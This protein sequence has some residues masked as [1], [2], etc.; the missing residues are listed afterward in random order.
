MFRFWGGLLLLICFA[1]SA[2]SQVIDLGMLQPAIVNGDVV[3]DSLW[4]LRAITPRI[5]T[6][7]TFEGKTFA[8]LCT[9][10]LIAPDVV[11]TAAHCLDT[12]PGGVLKVEVNFGHIEMP[13]PDFVIHP[14][15]QELDTTLQRGRP[16]V[17]GGFND[18]G[19]IFLAKPVY[20]APP[21][22]L[23]QSDYR[24]KD[25]QKVLMAGYGKL[26]LKEANKAE[27]LYFVEVPVREDKKGRLSVE[28]KKTS[29]TGDSGGPLLLRRDNRWLSVGVISFGT[30]VDDAT[31]MRTSYYTDW[32]L[33]E[34]Q[35]YRSRYNI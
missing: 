34:I 20:H 31:P 22:L 8:G 28:G 1:L 30:C 14:L 26:G 24:L 16:N 35:I 4:D 10:L 9:G 12:D 7:Y 3:P 32:I 13:A 25:R 17:T 19:L 15:Y 6:T 29:C 21:A 27:E 18:V 2:H 5:H 11:L 23:P 33:E